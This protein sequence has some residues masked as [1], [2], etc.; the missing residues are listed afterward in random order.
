ML[1]RSPEEILSTLD[2]HGALDGLPFM[3]EMLDACGK[4]FRVQRRVEK[5]CVDGHPLRRFPANDVVILDGPRCDGQGHDGCKHRCRIF[6]KEAWLRRPDV[7]TTSPGSQAG[8]E[9]LRARLKVKADEE[10]YFCQSTQL[11]EATEPF[12]GR[13]RVWMLRILLREIRTG[14]VSVGRAVRLVALW[15]RQVLWRAAGGDEHVAGP[16]QRT[17]TRSLGL[18]PGEAVRVKSRAEVVATLDVRSR[19]RGLAICDEVLRCCGEEAVVRDRVDRLIDERTGK[20]REISNTVTL[21]IPR[22]ESLAEECLCY[23]EIGDCPRGEIMYWREIWLER[24]NR[25]TSKP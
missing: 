19:N 7:E 16:N 2:A 5:T 6:W 15:L 3:P 11:L 18:Q 10:R 25:T 17:P 22:N 20:M 13:Q 14:D 24:V 23:H 12:P 4:V 9:T 21:R 1:V 8:L